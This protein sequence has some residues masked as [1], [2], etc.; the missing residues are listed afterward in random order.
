MRS[1]PTLEQSLCIPVRGEVNIELVLP[2]M[3]LD[4]LDQM[5]QDLLAERRQVTDCFEVLRAHVSL[6]EICGEKST[7][8]ISV[9]VAHIGILVSVSEK[10]LE[11]V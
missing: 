10:P 9:E 4:I 11:K 7:Q 6:M 8:R 5:L 1:F 3:R 2:L